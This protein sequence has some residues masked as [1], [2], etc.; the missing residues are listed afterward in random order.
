MILGKQ[1]EPEVFIPET[2]PQ[3]RHRQ[4]RRKFAWTLVGFHAFV[5]YASAVLPPAV[6]AELGWLRF[7]SDMAAGCGFVIFAFSPPDRVAIAS[8]T[9]VHR[10]T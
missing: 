10:Q 8:T 1:Q 3:R 4:F 6:R 5:L 9:S 7:F 2:P